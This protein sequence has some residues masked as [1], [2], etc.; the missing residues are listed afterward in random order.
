M[1]AEK[2]KATVVV[3]NYNRADTI[4]TMLQALAK[5]TAPPE[6]FEA[7]VVDDG[8]TD[9][10]AEII[11]QMHLPYSLKL[12][13]QPNAGAGAARNRGVE[14]A[15]A[16]Y[17]IFLDSDMIAAPNLV[18]Q[19]LRTSEARPDA[20]VIGRQNPFPAAFASLFDQITH[21]EWFRDFGPDDFVPTFYHVV[22]SNMA[23]SRDNYARA[24]GFDPLVGVGAHPATDDTELGYRAQKAGLPLAYCPGALAFHDHPRTFAQRCKQ[25]HVG[26][27]WMAKF[28]I[29]HPDTWDLVPT[30]RDV[31]PISWRKD[32]MALGAMKM[33][34]RLAGT[35]TSVTVMQLLLPVAER[36]A[37]RAPRL[38]S[39]LYWG[40]LGAHRYQGFRN[41]LHAH[42]LKETVQ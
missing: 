13:V 25:E 30:F 23:I 34:R 7:I 17:L 37:S 26:A 9:S 6:S 4:A 5:Q 2:P 18:E 28:M 11:R 36:Y 20:L 39:S 41:G 3:P 32:R 21:Y 38:L 42:L 29:R 24:G 14:E 8:S 1:N 16:S 15:G 10:S 19:Y 40:I 31:Q 22:S 12:V 27:W 33:R 35:P